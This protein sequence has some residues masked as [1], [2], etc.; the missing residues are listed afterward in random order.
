MV[1][2]ERGGGSWLHVSRGHLITREVETIFTP[3][4]LVALLET[5]P[6]WPIQPWISELVDVTDDDVVLTCTIG[7]PAPQ[8]EPGAFHMSYSLFDSLCRA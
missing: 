6:T 1:I 7:V 8:A 5:D 4:E 2:S 3:D